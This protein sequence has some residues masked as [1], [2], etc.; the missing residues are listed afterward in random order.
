MREYPIIFYH[1]I[2][3]ISFHPQVITTQSPTLIITKKKFRNAINKIKSGITVI[4]KISEGHNLRCSNSL[5]AEKDKKQVS[6]NK[7]GR[8]SNANFAALNE[9][10]KYIYFS[11]K[12]FYFTFSPLFPNIFLTKLLFYPHFNSIFKFNFT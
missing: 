12:A 5:F 2:I 8:P 7:I 4:K 6:G 9:R 1:Q 11:R 3:F 10:D